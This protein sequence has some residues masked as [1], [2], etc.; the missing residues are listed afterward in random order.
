MPAADFHLLSR[1]YQE[2]PWG[3]WR[4]NMHAALIAREIARTRMKPRAQIDLDPWMVQHPEK[5]RRKRL[6]GFVNA[7]KGMAG[8]RIHISEHNARKRKAKQKHDDRP[9]QTGRAAGSRNGKVQR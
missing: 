4:D 3:A 2:E 8:E 6:S 9:R 7:L 1:Y 5:R